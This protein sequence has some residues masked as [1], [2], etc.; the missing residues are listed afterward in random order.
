MPNRVTTYTRPDG[1]ATVIVEVR[2]IY[3]CRAELDYLVERTEKLL[4]TPRDIDES[5]LRVAELEVAAEW[6]VD[7]VR[8]WIYPLLDEQIDT[9]Y[10][11]RNF[12]KNGKASQLEGHQESPNLRGP[13][14]PPQLRERLLA[15]HENAPRGHEAAL[16]N[17]ASGSE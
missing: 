3:V 10:W 16:G 2:P 12:G 14:G 15:L 5:H 7:H 9:S 17:R 8:K 13:G 6:L 1:G 4:A 11:E